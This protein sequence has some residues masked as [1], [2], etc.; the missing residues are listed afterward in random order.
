MVLLEVASVPGRK[1][2]PSGLAVLPI[3]AELNPRTPTDRP[4]SPSMKTR[5]TPNPPATS[6]SPH[7]S[8]PP[9]IGVGPRREVPIQVLNRDFRRVTHP[10]HTSHPVQAAPI[11]FGRSAWIL[12]QAADRMLGPRFSCGL[13]F[14]AQLCGVAGPF[15]QS[16]R[17]GS[18]E[19]RVSAGEHAEI[20]MRGPR[21]EPVSLRNQAVASKKLHLFTLVSCNS[22]VADRHFDGPRHGPPDP[23][24]SSPWAQTLSPTAPAGLLHR[25]ASS[26]LPP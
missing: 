22:G 21:L 19:P 4:P 23:P 13:A 25:T 11:S 3:A 10:P 5:D 8:Q 17:R 9:Q 7:T 12:V 20:L 18:L 26:F 6:P 1:R 16:G 14:E 24:I 15:D 2:S